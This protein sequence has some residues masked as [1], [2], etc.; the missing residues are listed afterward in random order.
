[1]KHMDLL[2]I[3][4]RILRSTLSSLVHRDHSVRFLSLNISTISDLRLK[5][6]R[7]DSLE[8]SEPPCWVQG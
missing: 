6:Q 4:V 8:L 2:M 7:M 3:T 5:I 1:M